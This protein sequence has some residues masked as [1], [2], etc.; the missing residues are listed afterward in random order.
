[1]DATARVRPRRAGAERSQR[2]PTIRFQI[3]SDAPHQSRFSVGSHHPA[4]EGHFPGAPVVPGVILLE[5]VLRTAAA[6]GYAA[7]GVANAKFLEPL[8]PAHTFTVEVSP[9]DTGRLGFR[10][11]HEG[12]LIA[13]G[14]LVCHAPAPSV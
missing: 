12:R 1:M 13:Q 4:I 3:V 2:K 10:I 5:R 14:T 7:A 6:E 9:E 8:A 11:I